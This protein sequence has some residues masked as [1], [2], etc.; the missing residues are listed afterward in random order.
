MDIEEGNVPTVT[1]NSKLASLTEL[2]NPNLVKQRKQA[3]WKLEIK[4]PRRMIERK[5][6]R[7]YIAYVRKQETT[8]S[9]IAKI[10]W[11][12]NH[13]FHFDFVKIICKTSIPQELDFWKLSILIKTIV[14]MS[15]SGIRN[16]H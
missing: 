11:R 16:L 6:I 8:K 14:I 12:N 9:Y 3:N 13:K 4:H 15:Q 1:T 7:E 2:T 5:I 10:C